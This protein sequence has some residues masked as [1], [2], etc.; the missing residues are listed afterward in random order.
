MLY[1]IFLNLRGHQCLILGGGAVAERKAR[2]L[3]KAG[4]RVTVVSLEFTE[5]LKKLAKRHKD[6]RLAAIT[7]STVKGGTA[8]PWMRAFPIRPIGNKSRL[9]SNT[10]PNKYLNND[11]ALAFA[12]TSDPAANRDF[13]KLCKQKGV[14]VSQADDQEAS[15]FLVPASLIKGKLH[16]ALSTSGLSPLFARQLKKKLA[17]AVGPEDVRFLDWFA[18]SRRR[19]K[20]IRELATPLER[21]RF[22]ERLLRPEFLRLF[23]R[24]EM[25]KIEAHFKGLLATFKKEGSQAS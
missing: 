2:T 21:Q 18:S 7:R 9:L 15:D 1:P 12:C 19:P 10:D 6:L 4:A 13:V 16:V 23:R 3:L 8:V 5:G 22:F 14:W 20:V 17:K 25:G 11:T 24:P